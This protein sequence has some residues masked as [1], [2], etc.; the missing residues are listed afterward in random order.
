MRLLLTPVA[1]LVLP[2][3]FAL[4]AILALLTGIALLAKFTLFAKLALL[5]G[6]AL[7]AK[8]TLLMG[9]A[10]FSKLALL[11]R[12]ALLAGFALLSKFALLAE[13]ALLARVRSLLRRPAFLNVWP[14]RLC[15]R[16][17]LYPLLIVLPHPVS[18]THLT[19]PTNRE[20]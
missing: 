15:G 16:P 11:A 19:L 9:F 2:A 18:Y 10:L 8:L 7:L 4:F 5:T 1:L 14:P 20:V 13:F 6:I 17:L 3:E 12:I